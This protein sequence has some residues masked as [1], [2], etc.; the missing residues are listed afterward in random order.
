[1]MKTV[2]IKAEGRQWYL[3]G[4]RWYRLRLYE[5]PRNK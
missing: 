1:M 3:F 2:K 5:H 4:R